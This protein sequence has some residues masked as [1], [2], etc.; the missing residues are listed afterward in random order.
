MKKK[1]HTSLNQVFLRLCT[2]NCD[3]VIRIKEDM[4]VVWPPSSYWDFLGFCHFEDVAKNI[5]LIMLIILI[6][7]VTKANMDSLGEES[8]YSGL[9]SA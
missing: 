8:S 4:A 9:N 3:R 7:R 1:L 6:I 5:D 2:K